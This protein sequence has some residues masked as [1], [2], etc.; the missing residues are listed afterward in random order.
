MVHERV[1]PEGATLLGID[2]RDDREATRDFIRDRGITYPSIYECPGR[3]LVALRG[4]SRSTVQR[5]SC[6]TGGTAWRRSSCSRSGSTSYSRWCNGS[7]PKPTAAPASGAV[8]TR[9][10]G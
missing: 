1:Q 8:V 7:R 9:S 4:F 3:S 5:R 6:W 10:L 2:V